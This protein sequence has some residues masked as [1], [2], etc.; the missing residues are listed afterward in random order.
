M[1]KD[2]NGVI[3]ERTWFDPELFSG[4]SV[5]KRMELQFKLSVEEY[6][7]QAKAQGI[8]LASPLPRHQLPV[9]KIVNGA[10]S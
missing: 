3:F 7:R 8:K 1:A 10:E 5:G 4:L 2:E 6:R 9:R